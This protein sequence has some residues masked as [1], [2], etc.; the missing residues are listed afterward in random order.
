M[1]WS[2]MVTVMRNTGLASACCGPPLR[3]AATRPI[4]E[5]DVV[6]PQ[7]VHESGR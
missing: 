3:T 2:T 1:I 6:Q 5:P 4:G 7:F